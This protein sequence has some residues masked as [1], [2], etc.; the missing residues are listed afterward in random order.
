MAKGSF[1]KDVLKTAKQSAVKKISSAVFGKGI[2]GSAMGKSFDRKFGADEEDGSEV[3]SSIDEQGNIQQQNN[4]T[5][6]RIETIV[7]NIADNIYNI[8]GVLNAQVVSMKEAQRLQQERAFKE[9]A[10]KE[11][12]ASEATKIGGPVAAGSEDIGA[13]SNKGGFADLL[14]SLTGTKLRLKGFLKKFGKVAIG[15]SAV[16]GAG[17]LYAGTRPSDDLSNN[18]LGGTTTDVSTTS[19]QIS[20][21]PSLPVS[22]PVSNTQP[23]A[24]PLA[25]PT[26]RT[27]SI[28][29]SQYIRKSTAPVVSDNAPTSAPTAAASA[30]TSTSPQAVQAGNSKKDA[31]NF[32]K[33]VLNI[34]PNE[35][36]TFTDATTNAPVSKSEVIQKIV[37]AGGQPEKIISAW[38]KPD[39]T[40]AGVQPNIGSVS[41]MLS[42]AVASVGSS[43][44]AV[45][46]SSSSPIG[47]SMI[48][49]LPP[50]VGMSIG[51]TSTSIAAAGE[52]PTP[53]NTTSMVN[54]ASSE[55]NPPPTSI[56]SPIA[57]RGSLDSD[58]EFNS[59]YS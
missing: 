50:S 58:T 15:L 44:S 28:P 34:T 53:Q 33:S 8:A 29:D 51:A 41:D 14:G 45:S 5:L 7:M 24:P 11:E 4:A 27:G 39:Q 17:A 38:N 30:V 12:A 21:P 43:G 19:P 40:K 46:P 20:S 16:V 1:T 55:G 42:S 35:D 10:A 59:F 23:P 57:S 49:P 13:T 47:A 18:T 25:Q 26:T 54:T 6:E 56:P 31:Q 48:P 37:T 22:P 52:A 36:G 9:G 32:F 2:I 3:T